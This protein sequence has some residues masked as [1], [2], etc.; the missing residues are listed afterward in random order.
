LTISGEKAVIKS[1]PAKKKELQSPYSALAFIR[2][3]GVSFWNL[4]VSRGDLGPSGIL[5]PF[6]SRLFRG[7]GIGAYSSGLGL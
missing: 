5:K 2:K 6:K 7:F 1:W 3:A 4:R